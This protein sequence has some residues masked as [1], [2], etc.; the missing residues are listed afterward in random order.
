MNVR[1]ILG[2]EGLIA[3][4]LRAYEHRPQQL[5]MAEAV[6]Q[7]IA[8]PGHLMVEAGTGVGK[9]FAYLIPA[10]LACLGESDG[11]SETK[12][13][14][15]IVVA[16]HTISLQEQ[17]IQKDIPFLRA[18]LPQEFSAVLVK[19]RSNYIS[20]R[21]LHAAQERAASTFFAEEEFD[22]LRRI[23][24]WAKNT[25]DGSLSDMSFRPMWPVW[26]EVQS[27]SGNCLGRKCPTY[28]ACHFY[29]ARRRV[30][31]A[32]ILVVNHSLFFSDLALRRANASILPDYDV[33]IL[34]EAHQLESSAASYFG[35]ELSNTQVERFLNKLYNPRTNRGLMTFHKFND[36]EEHVQQ[37][38][39]AADEFFDSIT[40]WRQSQ[41]SSNG[42]ARTPL[43]VYDGLTPKLRTLGM[44]L[45]TL[46][47]RIERDE[48]RQ[49]V[50]AASERAMGLAESANHWMRQGS[51]GQVYWTEVS[52]GKRR[53]VALA[54]ASIDVGPTLQAELYQKVPTCILTSATLS[55]GRQPS[56]EFFQQRLGLHQCQSLR[57]GSP[58][59]YR[60]Q[61]T[62]H[63]AA[64]LPDPAA[65][66]TDFESVAPDVIK[67]YLSLTQGGAFVLFTSYRMLKD[68]ATRLGAWL[69]AQGMPAFSQADGVPRTKLLD[70]FRQH[71]N[72]VLF[73]TDSFW[74]GVDVPG[75]ALRNVIITKLPF[76]VP[77]HPLM[78]ARLEDIRSRGGSP[79][80]DYQLPEAVLKL[81]QGFGRLIR[82]RTDSGIV[83]ILD[84]RVLTKQYG[85]LFLESLPDCKQRLDTSESY[86]GFC[87]Q[88]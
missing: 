53:R 35:S 10:I 16:T 32:Q 63:I 44:L 52:T 60:E 38:R 39:Y 75:E 71:R 73:G 45:G 42:R 84:P 67:Y 17:L 46:A 54:S 85:N 28:K 24:G 8:R 19:G 6:A 82:T 22:Q 4:R 12:K 34:D 58:F 3:R 55:I 9:S 29:A 15:K 56:F 25:R 68:A 5:E 78:E 40:A 20:L 41:S 1:E 81:K 48:Q 66:R 80:M 7:A 61:V 76:S 2:P 57:L 14:K 33:V 47:D 21:R 43:Q 69:A 23:G 74:Q 50:T 79:F 11:S 65:R 30:H 72:S 64:E 70:Q 83:A 31:N 18:V 77:D 62:V 86:A 26:E 37:T 51:P 36:G 13:K 88:S 59:N 27:E 87:T 49:E